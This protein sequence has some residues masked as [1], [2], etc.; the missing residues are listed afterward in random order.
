MKYDFAVLFFPSLKFS[1]GNKPIKV[2]STASLSLSIFLRFTFLRDIF[3]GTRLFKVVSL[4]F[5]SLFF[6]IFICSLFTVFVCWVE[7]R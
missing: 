4:H 3:P 1:V 5:T 7:L 6:F 2:R